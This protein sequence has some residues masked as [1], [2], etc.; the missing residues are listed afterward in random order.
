MALT[1][2]VCV[3]SVFVTVTVC[4][5]L[6]TLI[7][8]CGKV[9]TLGVTVLATGVPVPARLIRCGLPG[10]LSMTVTVALRGPRAVGVKVTLIVHVPDGA[11]TGAICGWQLS[12]SEYEKS[13]T[14]VPPMLMLLTKRVPVLLVLVNVTD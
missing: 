8:C 6:G 7:A 5:A 10:A 1:T 3:G 4:A 13:P 9:N 12:D 14:L 2:S 11:I